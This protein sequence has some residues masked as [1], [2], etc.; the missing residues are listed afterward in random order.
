MDLPKDS[1]AGEGF[2]IDA[3]SLDTLTIDDSTGGFCVFQSQMPHLVTADID[4]FTIDT[5]AIF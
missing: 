2:V 5:L 1:H 4:F 3:P